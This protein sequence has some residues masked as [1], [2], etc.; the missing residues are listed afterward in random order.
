MRAIL[1]YVVARTILK[2]K[3]DKLRSE[4]CKLWRTRTHN[5]FNNKKRRFLASQWSTVRHA[6]AQAEA[7]LLQGSGGTGLVP[8]L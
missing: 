6:L 3:G 8:A 1:Y 4:F 2:A 7:G 5:F